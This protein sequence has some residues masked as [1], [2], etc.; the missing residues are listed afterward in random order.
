MDDGIS[1]ASSRSID[2][3]DRKRF[4]EE[5]FD[6]IC[7]GMD[8]YKI[9]KLME[10]RLSSQQKIKI[11]RG[12]R[13]Q[14]DYSRRILNYVLANVN[15]KVYGVFLKA[16]SKV[17]P[18]IYVK[19][20]KNLEDSDA[21][22]VRCESTATL[23]EDP[24]EDSG[25][26]I[27]CDVILTF[28]A[29][30]TGSDIIRALEGLS[31]RSLRELRL[32]GCHLG[33]E[34]IPQICEQLTKQNRLQKINLEK[35]NLTNGSSNQIFDA[36]NNKDRLTSISIKGIVSSEDLTDC[37]VT[38][39]RTKNA[40]TELCFD[41]CTWFGDNFSKLCDSLVNLLNLT[42]LSCGRSKLTDTD[43]NDL[44]RS[45]GSHKGMKELCFEWNF[46]SDF[47]VTIY[48]R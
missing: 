45:L 21:L 11:R 28:K 2:I 25:D 34:E 31:P 44:F 42:K 29:E 6:T 15:D 1:M 30:Q 13:G 36:L 43:M 3:D 5:K 9:M 17:H 47:S 7:D 40:L 24:E 26:E 8:P 14:D 32:I 27:D 33:D 22:K 18:E 37:L 35:G 20:L 19:L 23:V 10:K 48:C 38:A 41:D 39:L 16:L 46:I 12:T 4:I